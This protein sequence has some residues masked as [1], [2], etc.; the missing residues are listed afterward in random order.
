MRRPTIQ[1][2]PVTVQTSL[3][4]PAV[5]LPEPTDY[6]VVRVAK[7]VGDDLRANILRVLA[8]DSFGVQE[9]CS[10]FSAAQPALSHH[11]KILRDANL[12]SQRKEGTNI[13][14]RRSSHASHTLHSALFAAVD[15]QP[16][17]SDICAQIHKLNQQRAERCQTFFANN[18]DVLHQQDE[19]ICPADV[20]LPCVMQ[21]LPLT[22]R[23]GSCA[24]EV[25][26]GN[27]TLLLQLGERYAQVVGMD[28]SSTMLA[29]TA[30]SIAQQPATNQIKLVRGD[31]F[32]LADDAHFD[33]LIAAM[34]LHHMPSPEAFF[35]KAAR[36]TCPGGHLVIAELCAH[37]QD[38]VT[39]TVG[40]LWLG[41]EP[42]V[43][44]QWAEGNG[45]K[46]QDQQHLA[47]RNGFQVQV[48]SFVRNA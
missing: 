6:D 14:Y 1:R 47:Q 34:V 26:P 22:P 37:T 5:L 9:L 16:L 21:N 32:S 12:V 42:T 13:F 17:S 43:L 30:D 46:I 27:G 2:T 35:Q 40:D 19:L 11:L 8:A 7:A 24:L 31:F 18:R 48:L 38:W 33:A 28:S 44:T 15:A 20:Y 25:G 41:F 23:S 10:I 45:F 29:A 4:K 3:R 36:V 39:K